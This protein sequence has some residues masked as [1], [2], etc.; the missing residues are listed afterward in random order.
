[1]LNF[2]LF[3]LLVFSFL[4]NLTIAFYFQRDIDSTDN[5]LGSTENSVNNTTYTADPTSEEKENP[6]FTPYYK[7]MSTLLNP[8]M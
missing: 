2:S 5:S 1:M 3:G 6:P 7:R 4:L 8:G